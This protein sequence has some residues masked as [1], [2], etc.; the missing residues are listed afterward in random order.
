MGGDQAAEVLTR[1]RAESDAAKGRSRSDEEQE[2]Y[3]AQIRAQY[4]RQGHPYH[5]SARL[6]DDGVIDPADTRRV[7]AL[8][9]AAA[10]NAPVEETRFGLFRM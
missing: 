8:C 3:R 1:V 4:E 5:A 9:L 6:W 10:S 7:L 2:I